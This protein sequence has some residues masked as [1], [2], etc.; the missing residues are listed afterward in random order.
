M[1]EVSRPRHEK[2]AKAEGLLPELVSGEHNGHLI[3]PE[4]GF[5]RV[6]HVLA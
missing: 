6:T 2:Q 4:E 5:R 3:F 1:E